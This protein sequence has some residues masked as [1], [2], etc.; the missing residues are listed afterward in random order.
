[1]CKNKRVVYFGIFLLLFVSIDVIIIRGLH[2]EEYYFQQKIESLLPKR[3]E[4][5]EM[6]QIRVLIKTEGFKQI[7]HTEVSLQC[8]A[9]IVLKAGE[10]IEEYTGTEIITITP[11]DERFEQGTIKIEG[12]NSAAKIGITS[13]ERG[14]GTPDYRGSLELFCT[15][16]GIVIVN[17][18]PL[19]QYLYAV[20]PSEM[21][22]S[23]E[24]EALKV[25]AVCA[26]S[27]AYNQSREY[28]YP[29][30]R[31]HVD[32]STSFQVYGN[33]KEQS[34]TIQAVNSTTGEMLWYNGRVATA[35]YYST[36]CGRTSS[37]RAWE[38]EYNEYNQYLKS[39]EVCDED[40]NAYEKDLPWYQWSAEIKKETLCEL[41]E[42]NT[43][44]EIGNL[45][46]FS[47]TKH[48]DGG[49]VQQIT[50]IGS[51][52]SVVVE[53]ENKIRRALGGDGYIIEKQDGTIINS[54]ALFPSAFFSISEK[55]DRYIFKGGGYGHG[56]GMS[57]NGA[58]E[59]AKAGK[60][61]REILTTFY[62]NVEIK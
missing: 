36:S 45:Q 57:Q 28:A 33:S 35:Y 2:K 38:T 4:Q 21:P 47:V 13:I 49:I 58:N 53:T 26:R 14:Y 24:Q 18:L 43:G 3:K 39:V 22:A 16:E 20:V 7:T 23:Y 59:M 15:A 29:E 30:Y 61:Y 55:E 46:S 52:G 50:A 54:T 37:I 60:T 48:G 9:G 41:L 44:T 34:S 5:L 27:Y 8:S 10:I 12:K 19:E 6:D 11:E 56:I 31:A 62:S 17:E 1:M 40:G 42:L 25:Q 51:K 32:D